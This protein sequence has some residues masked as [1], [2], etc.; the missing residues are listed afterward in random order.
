MLAQ[1]L[2]TALGF[3]LLVLVLRRFFW[4]AVLKLLDERRQ[5]IEES[6]QSIE[7]AK[8]ELESLQADYTRR[9]GTI[10]EEAR[11]K[12]RQAIQ[13]GRRMASEIQDEARAQSH[14]IIAKSKETIE[15]ELAKAKVSLRDE[16]AD[17]TIEAVERLLRQKLDAK[18][19]QQLVASILEELGH[20]EPPRE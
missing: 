19:D 13:E 6:F 10:D 4:G 5:R 1:I 18:A 2:T 11:E 9:L 8:R 15:L 14:G 12:I 20:A 3:F 7:H 17:M 16:L